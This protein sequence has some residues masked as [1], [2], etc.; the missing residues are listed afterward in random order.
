MNPVNIQSERFMALVS[1]VFEDLQARTTEKVTQQNVADYIGCHQSYV[2]EVVRGARGKFGSDVINKAIRK[3]RLKPMFFYD[4]SLKNPHYRDY[5][6]RPQLAH[7]RPHL[8][9]AEPSEEYRGEPLLSIPQREALASIGGA[10]EALRERGDNH[11][12]LFFLRKAVDKLTPDDGHTPRVRHLRPRK[13]NAT[14]P[15]GKQ[16]PSG[17]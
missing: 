7:E 14:S 13:R 3:L 15:R 1:Q 17:K 4:D 6:E 9:V 8:R 5:Q 11:E 16:K 2:S 10:Q 12:A